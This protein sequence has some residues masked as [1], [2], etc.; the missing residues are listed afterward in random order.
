[1]LKSIVKFILKNKRSLFYAF[2]TGLG[3]FT[4]TRMY[5]DYGFEGFF[6]TIGI[7]ACILLFE[8]YLNWR[9]A[10]KILR[11]IDMPNVNTYNLWGN[12]LN[13]ILLPVLLFFTITGFIYFNIDPLTRF[14]AICICFTVNLFLFINIRSYYEDDFRIESKTRYVYDIA[15]LFIFF[16]GVN[17][18]IHMQISMDPGEWIGSVLICSLS[19]I[20]GALLLYRKAQLSIVSI[21]YI[22][23]ASFV[24]AI[25][26]MVLS[27][28]GLL[29]LG[30]NVLTFLLFYL[31]LSIL[32]HRVERTLTVGILVEYLLIFVIAVT[33]F[34]G[35]S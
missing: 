2:L 3:L 23:L 19:I 8:I 28:L 25:F 6:A 33:I 34:L 16:F 9:F 31:A 26:Y 11:Q 27:S 10:T 21:I 35:I 18:I 24:I 32:H 4:S 5:E 30:I 14:L 12:L 15:K 20:L 7:T 13:H 22:L 1:L 17:L 29:F